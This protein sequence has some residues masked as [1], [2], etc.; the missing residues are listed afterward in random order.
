MEKIKNKENFDF[1]K[2]LILLPNENLLFPVLNSIP[3]SIS[4]INVTMGFPL[5]ETPLYDLIQIILKVKKNV[6]VRDHQN[7]SYYKDILE[8]IL[9]PYVY[10]YDISF[11]EKIVEKLNSK[12][13]IYVPN[14]Y[15]KEESELLNIILN[16]PGCITT[17]ILNVIKHFFNKIELF[18]QLDK[19][20]FI[21]FNDL[22]ERLL[23]IN[24]DF[25]SPDMLSKLLSQ[26]TKLIKIPFSGEPLNGLQIMGVLESRNLDFD[27]VFIFSV[28]EGEFPKKNYSSSFIPFN[29]RK[30]FQL[31]TG[32]SIDKVYSYLFYRVMQRAKNIT[33]IYN[34]KSDFGSSGE[35]SRYVKQLELES[36]Y[37]I[38][39]FSSHNNIEVSSQG[40]ISIKK[41]ND[42]INKLKLRF[43]GKSYISPSA[44]KDYMSCSLK[45]YYNYI[46]NIKEI[47][48]FSD[49]IEKLEF[50]TLSHNALELLYN[51]ILK[52]KDVKVIDK[53]D[54]FKIKNSVEGSILSVTKKH[55]K[56]KKRSQFLLEGQNV[57]LFEIIKD[58]V[59][60]IIS[61][62]E[63]NAP[64]KIVDL[65]GDK[66]LGYNKKLN[67][68][69][70]FSINISGFIDRID[71]KDGV[72]RIID[73]KTGGDT[74]K[75]K[76]VDSLFS[77]ER[78]LRNDAVFQLF[79][80]SLLFVE[81]KGSDKPIIP[82][83]NNIREINNKNFDYKLIIGNQKINDIR[84]YLKS[85]E[86]LLIS[87]L[88]EIYDEKLMF[89]QTKDIEICKYC[90]YRNICYK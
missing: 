68:S 33:F 88:N 87:K 6:S 55:F 9:N 46:A 74:K 69:E 57:I 39:H 86:Q 20:Y 56:L 23:K 43:G 49:Q 83:L 29:I 28:N 47:R 37:S 63:K 54:F 90:S 30:G 79:F 17:T 26:I 13:L 21:Y 24:L 78:R 15:F 14:S 60:K 53:N 4:K 41:S 35:I 61:Y 42:L 27:H 73:Y 22:L 25:N 70:N 31:R 44:V 34:S 85:F 38:N 2:V 36:K 16:S 58:Y 7:C 40:S 12:Q 52:N 75:F 80:Y 8:L 81:N 5:S 59:S 51:D 48:P 64:F 11:S 89:E 10:Q 50:G 72:I 82:G 77:D 76:D 1:D 66:K 19:E 84:E 71:E 65:E 32:D 45:F 18:G 3:K 62:D 67:L